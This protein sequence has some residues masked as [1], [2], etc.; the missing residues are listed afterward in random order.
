MLQVSTETN[1]SNEKKTSYNKLKHFFKTRTLT[2][3]SF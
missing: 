2:G 1:I 3:T